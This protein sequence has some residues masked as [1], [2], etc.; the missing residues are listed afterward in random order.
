MAVQAQ[1]QNQDTS[2]LEI[3]LA[4]LLPV[5]L[6]GFFFLIFFFVPYINATV[7]GEIDSLSYL[8]RMDGSLTAADVLAQCRRQ[9]LRVGRELGKLDRR[10]VVELV[11]GGCTQGGVGVVDP[12]GQSVGPGK[13]GDTRRGQAGRRRDRAR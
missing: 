5:L 2:G 8:R 3:S 10:Q 13:Y 9:V 4:N 7:A 1:T 12:S 11:A 6:A